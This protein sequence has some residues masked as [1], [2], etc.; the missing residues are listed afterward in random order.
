MIFYLKDFVDSIGIMLLKF[1]LLRSPDIFWNH[2]SWSQKA[3]KRGNLEVY[4]VNIYIY[5]WLSCCGSFGIMSVLEQFRATSTCC[6]PL[7]SLAGLVSLSSFNHSSWL[8]CDPRSLRAKDLVRCWT[9]G[10]HQMFASSAVSSK[11][12]MAKNFSSWHK[13]NLTRTK[14]NL[15]LNNQIKNSSCA[16]MKYHTAIRVTCY[17]WRWILIR[18]VNAL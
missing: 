2:A 8:Q 9:C 5:A 7:A 6:C 1:R 13:E 11:T 18:G 17:N 10:F 3:W 16:E 14:A 12:K 15:R 4:I